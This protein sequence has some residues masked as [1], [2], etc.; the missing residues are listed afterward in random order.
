VSVRAEEAIA[1]LVKGEAK[2]AAKDLREQA[3]DRGKKAVE[4]FLDRLR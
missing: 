4:G 3:E 1:S 2:A